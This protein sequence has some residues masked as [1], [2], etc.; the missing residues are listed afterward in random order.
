MPTQPDWLE[1]STSEFDCGYC[2]GRLDIVFDDR[3]TPGREDWLACPHCG[4]T[5]HEDGEIREKAPWYH[6]RYS[7]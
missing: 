4:W 1:V 3:E 6:A 2:R 7:E 5:D